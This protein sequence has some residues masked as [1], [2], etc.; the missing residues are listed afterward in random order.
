MKKFSWLLII[1]M[2][3]ITATVFMADLTQDIIKIDTPKKKAKAVETQVVFDHKLHAETHAKTCDACH[4]AIKDVLNA[5]ENVKAIV[6]TTC[7]T[8]HAKDKPGKSFK[9]SL[10]HVAKAAEVK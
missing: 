6:H 1:C 7:K 2:L 9:C 10:C 3:F 5:P 4:P 8:C